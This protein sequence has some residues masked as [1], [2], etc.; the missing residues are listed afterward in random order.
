[1]EAEQRFGEKLRL[2]DHLLDADPGGSVGEQ[3]PRASG[4]DVGDG[5]AA[6]ILDREDVRTRDSSPVHQEKV[7][8]AGGDGGKN[9]RSDRSVGI[10]IL[11][12][13]G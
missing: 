9:D 1:L 3:S 13:L 2:S 10:Q 12:G 6:G 5:V 7:R 11:N 4:I 8:I